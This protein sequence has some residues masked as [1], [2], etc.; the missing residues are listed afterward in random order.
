MLADK[1]KGIESDGYAMIMMHPRDFVDEDGNVDPAKLDDIS[2]LTTQLRADGVGI[3]T[4]Q[5]IADIKRVS[6]FGIPANVAGLS[7]AATLYVLKARVD[8]LS[9]L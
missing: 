1:R 5:E 8:Y 4:V 3:V 2:K 6:E 7:L 9:R